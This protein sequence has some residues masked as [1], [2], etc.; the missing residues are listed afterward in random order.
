[1]CV[2]VYVLVLTRLWCAYAE[3][4]G[5]HLLRPG[6][7]YFAGLSNVATELLRNK[8]QVFAFFRRDTVQR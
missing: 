1:V 4:I 6:F 2:C 7:I 3:Y 8:L 5:R